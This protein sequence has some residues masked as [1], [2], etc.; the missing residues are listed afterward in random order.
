M[1]W[2]TSE[3]QWQTSEMQ[4]ATDETAWDGGGGIVWPTTSN[5]QRIYTLTLT[6]DEDDL[7]DI[8]IP[9]TSCQMRRRDGDPSY[10]S[11]VVPD[12]DE[13]LADISARSNGHLV[14]SGGYKLSD[15]TSEVVEIAR[16]DLEDITPNAGARSRAITLMG[17]QSAYT[18]VTEERV[19]TGAGTRSVYDGVLSFRTDVDLDLNP[20][21]TAIVDGE[22]F[23]VGYIS[24]TIGTSTEYMDITESS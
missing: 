8:T 9:I 7:D 10:M 5:I 22:S 3:E 21:D 20:G 13:Y 4:W 23:T 2:L 11:V 17:H 19:I 15:G 14:F 18:L 1:Q 16:V 12:Y 24:Y 6:G